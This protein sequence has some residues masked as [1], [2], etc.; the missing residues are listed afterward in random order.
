MNKEEMLEVF[1]EFFNDGIVSRKTNVIFIRSIAKKDNA[2]R[3]TYLRPI[4]L[5]INLH[6]IIAKV[7][8]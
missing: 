8:L 1:W 3:V 5:I 6:K 7:C 2:S 4:S